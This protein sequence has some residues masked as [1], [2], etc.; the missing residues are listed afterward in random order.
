[1]EIL[2]PSR[3]F[4]EHMEAEQAKL[5]EI[6]KEL[7]KFYFD[8]DD[9]IKDIDPLVYMTGDAQDAVDKLNRAIGE[10]VKKYRR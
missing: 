3:K 1:M 2:Y 4:L 9:D 10:Y 7:E 8:I 5:Q 6:S